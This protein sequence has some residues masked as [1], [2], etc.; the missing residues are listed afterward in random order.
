M[1]GRHAT[2]V[3]NA[4]APAAPKITHFSEE[5]SGLPRSRGTYGIPRVYPE[6]VEQGIHV[7]RKRVARLMRAAGLHGVS[8]RTSVR[9]TVRDTDARPGARSGAT[10]LP[11]HPY[12]PRE[13]W[14]ISIAECSLPL[15][16]SA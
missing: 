4:G 10:T 14:V 5:V 7:G 8:R 3:G 2:L 13:P 15:N 12:A 11:G 6:L 16:T 9:T 1:A